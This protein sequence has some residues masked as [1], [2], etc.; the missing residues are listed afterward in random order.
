MMDDLISRRNALELDKRFPNDEMPCITE[1]LTGL[2]RAYVNG[3]NDCGKQWKKEIEALPSVQTERKTGEWEPIRCAMFE[4]S[5]CGEIYTDLMAEEPFETC[6]AKY[7]PHC[8]AKMEV[9]QDD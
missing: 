1:E 7:C 4:C 2:K 6:G 9:E 3:W 8:G 5:E